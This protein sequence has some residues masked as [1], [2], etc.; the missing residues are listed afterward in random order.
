MPKITDEWD[1]PQPRWIAVENYAISHLHSSSSPDTVPSPATLQ[2]ALSNSAKAGLPDISVS[3]SQGKYLQLT[4]RLSRA[5]RILEL[6][7]L[8]GYSTMW[9]ATAAP[10]VHVTTVE[11]DAH[12]AQVARDNIAA[13]GLAARVDVRLGAGV[14]VLAE[15]GRQVAAGQRDAFDFFFIDADKPNNWNYVDLALGMC[16]PG[17][18][19]IVDNV[20]RSGYLVVEDSENERI[21]GARHVIEKIGKDPRVDGVVVQTVDEK[22]YDGFVLAVTK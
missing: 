8:G 13:A 6:G 1:P 5:K 14:D 21:E 9:L 3:P 4:A 15:L 17:S 20:V 11:L 18:C 12:R 2:H 22:G 10:D 19:I 7:T 16:V